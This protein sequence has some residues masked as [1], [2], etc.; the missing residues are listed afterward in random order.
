MEQEIL[1]PCNDF[2]NHVT[3]LNSQESPL[4]STNVQMKSICTKCRKTAWCGFDLK[5]ALI[6]C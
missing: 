2:L 5:Y 4:K 3:D 6:S 1:L